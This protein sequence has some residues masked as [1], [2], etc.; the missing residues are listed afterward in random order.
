MKYAHLMLM[1]I[2]A[3]VSLV[4]A[5]NIDFEHGGLTRQYR[6]H[7][8]E[9]LQ[10]NAPLVLALHGYC[11]GNNDMKNNFGWTEL[12]D[13]KG[14]VVAFPNGSRDQSNCRFWDVGY[15]FH[16]GLSDVDDD[17][18]LSSLAV[19]LQDIHGLDPARTFATGFSN[20]AEMCFQLA[21]NESE[22]FVA[23]A[24]I[25]GMMLDPLFT[26]CNPT[27]VRSILSM[28]GTS[29]GVTLYEGDLQN[30]GGWGPYHSIPATMAL[31]SNK[32]ETTDI[33]RTYLPNTD[34]G[35][36]ST[37]RLDVYRSTQ[38]QKQLK[39][40]LV[41]GGGH[42][43]PGQSG[44]M[45]IDATQ[46]VWDFFSTI[47]DSNYVPGDVNRDG[48][49]DGSDLSLVLGYWGGSNVDA[50]VNNDGFINGADITIVLGA[51]GGGISPP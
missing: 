48:Q 5:N 40:Y 9:N 25:I 32:L 12:A 39:Y 35:D 42:D 10:A 6:I 44:N 49:V 11:G 34:P 33:D 36:G 18:F 14:F 50:D 3:P 24:P 43:Y 29:D 38:N 21:C 26:N 8:P 41:I 31:W 7:I 4:A 27:I 45:D 30:T 46:E 28:N 1:F 51:W 22:T 37:V 19:H 47:S 13:E 20:G 17:G 2:V 23:L 16:Q 15:D